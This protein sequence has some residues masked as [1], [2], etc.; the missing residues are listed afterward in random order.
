MWK[1]TF[2]LRDSP[3]ISNTLSLDSFY[4]ILNEDP[5]HFCTN[6]ALY[7]MVPDRNF[8]GTDLLLTPLSDCLCTGGISD[9]KG[10]SETTSLFSF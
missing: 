10:D 7:C 9:G 8:Q 3:Q 4:M 5:C 1:S 6:S 2:N